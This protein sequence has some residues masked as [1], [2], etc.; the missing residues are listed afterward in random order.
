MRAIVAA[1]CLA[2]LLLAILMGSPA[3]AQCTQYYDPTV[4]VPAGFGA[5]YDVFTAGNPPLESV[6]CSSPPNISFVIGLANSPNQQIWNTAYLSKDGI[7]WTAIPL[8]SASP[9]LADGYFSGRAT[10]VLNLTSADLTNWNYIAFLVAYLRNGAWVYGCPDAACASPGW[11]LQAITVTPVAPHLIISF[12]PASP[13]ILDNVTVGTSISDVTVTWSDG[14]PFTGTLSFG[15]PDNN[16]GGICALVG[17]EINLGAALPPGS[18]TQNCTIV[19][20]Q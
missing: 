18:S 16:D 2:S 8:S 5:A 20:T 17:T 10:T 15:A 9:V 13:S 19:A 4:P 12:S 14:S 3:D 7:S 1:A 11:N 6:N